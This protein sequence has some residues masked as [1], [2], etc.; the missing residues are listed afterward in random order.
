MASHWL[1]PT[2]SCALC[3][4]LRA[5]TRQACT[6]GYLS[7]HPMAQCVVRAIKCLACRARVTQARS[8]ASHCMQCSALTSPSLS[9]LHARGCTKPSVHAKVTKNI[10]YFQSVKHV[11]TP[12]Q[13][14][15][16]SL[17]VVACEPRHDRCVP[18][19]SQHWESCYKTC[20]RGNAMHVYHSAK[21]QTRA[22]QE[23]GHNT[24]LQ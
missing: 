17:G 18:G 20:V 8:P 3:G 4:C 22:K 23:Y 16:Y 9:S 19:M 2:A 15:T 7:F 14:A 1:D 6:T 11:G 10:I 5:N 21:L 13:A 24:V 12:R